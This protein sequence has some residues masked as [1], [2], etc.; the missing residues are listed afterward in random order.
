MKPKKTLNLAISQELLEQFNTVCAHYGHGKQKGMVLS[1]AIL[2]FLRADPRQQGQFLHEV[3]AADIASG[4]K[5]M[6]EE[7]VQQAKAAGDSN[8]QPKADETKPSQVMPRKA[9]KK[10][11]KAVRG[12]SKLPN[13]DDLN[14]KKQR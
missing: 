5:K 11:G 4:V 2:M 14:R 7:K 6:L 8:H 13:I 12:I 9:A 3:L 10:A 1:A